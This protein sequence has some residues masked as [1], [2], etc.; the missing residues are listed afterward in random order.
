MAVPA[1][2]TSG[3]LMTGLVAD[4]SYRGRFRRLFA[5]S[6]PTRVDSA[7]RDVPSVLLDA[8]SRIAPSSDRAHHEALNRR[9]AAK[10]A[11]VATVITM[12][13][14]AHQL[15]ILRTFADPE[16]VR[17]SLLELGAWGYL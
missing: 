14:V 4:N 8:R 6:L 15:G 3:T 2:S 12:V 5:P 10:L 11:L 16:R 7:T 13:A 9:T 17:E 1:A